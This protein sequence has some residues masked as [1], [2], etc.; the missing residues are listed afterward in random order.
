MESRHSV[1]SEI[2]L[3]A[4]DEEE[5]ETY[6]DLCLGTSMLFCIVGTWSKG[7]LYSVLTFDRRL[8]ELLPDLTWQ[9]QRGSASCLTI[10][11]RLI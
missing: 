4:V 7:A 5:Q 3:A 10:R 9:E 11:V 8:H 2:S 6:Q 1:T